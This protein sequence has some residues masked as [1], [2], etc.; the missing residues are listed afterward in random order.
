LTH[1]VNLQS[2]LV[3]SLRTYLGFK[4]STAGK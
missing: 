3:G 1:I 2:S 4:C